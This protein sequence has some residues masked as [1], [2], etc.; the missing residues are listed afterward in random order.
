MIAD[1]T[2]PMHPLDTQTVCGECR[3]PFPQTEDGY[4]RFYYLLKPRRDGGSTRT[5]ICPAC[6]QKAHRETE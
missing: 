3:E 5:R 6:Y 1:R 4:P 2:T